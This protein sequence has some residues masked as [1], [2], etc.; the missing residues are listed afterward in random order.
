M[1][2]QDTK[3]VERML[4]CF[5]ANDVAGSLELIADDVLVD[6]SARP[7]GGIGRGHADLN[8]LV[9]DWVGAFESWE[10]EITAIE[11]IGTHVLVNATQR[12]TGKGSGIDI[13]LVYWTTFAVANGKITAIKLHLDEEDAR[14][15]PAGSA[16]RS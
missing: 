2:G 3:T 4:E 7:D 14:A 8:R 10:D 5:H 6:G 1:S 15:N 12:G 11:D 16:Q 9:G 13:E